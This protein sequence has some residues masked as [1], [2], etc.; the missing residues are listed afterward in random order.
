MKN[1]ERK[2][3]V[4]QLRK[5]GL[6][7]K[8]IRQK[9]SFCISKSTISNW[10]KDIELTNKQKDRLDKLFKQGSYR[11]RLL[12]PKI[13]QVKRAKEIEE[14]KERAK[15]EILPLNRNEF[16]LAG[17]MLYWAE[18][19]KSRY[20]DITNSDPF[21]IS[22]MTEWL[23]VI[24]RVPKEKFRASLHL[25]SGQNEEQIKRYWSKLTNIP[26]CQFGKSYIKRE[27]SGHRKNRIYKGTIKIRVCDSNLLYR[28]LG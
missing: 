4:R 25:H 21:L 24:C 5:C 20:V 10:C 12:G 8:E 2:E 22:F 14:I 18:G 27:G 11:G 3:I 1:W 9:I 19:A 15:S 17:L 6:S 7:Y 28:I 26:I 13:I 16:K 23:R